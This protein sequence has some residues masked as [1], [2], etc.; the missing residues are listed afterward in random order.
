MKKILKSL[1]T[2]IANVLLFF[3]IYVLT[4]LLLNYPFSFI[5]KYINIHP[6][7]IGVF[8]AFVALILFII[9]KAIISRITKK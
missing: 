4:I 1:V 8:V 5:F 7:L 2:F 9:V 3:F 6:Y